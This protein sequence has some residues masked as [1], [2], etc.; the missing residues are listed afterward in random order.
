MI[1]AGMLTIQI[2]IV[3]GFACFVSLV[4]KMSAFFGLRAWCPILYT[5]KAWRDMGNAERVVYG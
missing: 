3:P 1:K 5:V 4:V 2:I